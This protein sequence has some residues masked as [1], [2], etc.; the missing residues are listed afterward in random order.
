MKI[1]LGIPVRM[2]STRFPGKPLCDILGKS[3]VEHVYRRCA[4]SRY[5]T[6]LFVAAC[7][8]EVKDHVEGF[9]GKVVMTDP[10]ISRA[11]LRV[12]TAA[13][14]YDLEPED[15]VVVIQGDEPLVH[16]E[17]IDLAIKP[18]LEE[19]D[20]FVSNL[21]RKIEKDEWKDPA[22][23]KVVC[24]L[25][26]NAMYMS[27]S[28]IPSIAHEEAR[29]DWWKQVCIMPFRW[30]FMQKFN[31]ELAETPLE[32]QESVEMLRAMQHGYKVRMVPSLYVSKS[33]DTEN[34]R[35]EVARLMA[36]DVIYK[37][38]K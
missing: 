20:L 33:V 3:M 15:I 7:D 5:A 10:K 35:Q 22:E 34:D 2:A 23:I 27:R 24:D 38:Y 19:K 18:L 30:H 11:G 36:D 29:C 6:D 1:M 26:M 13:E 17:M 37:T 14:T 16:P 8:P 31:H 12:A 9:G 21:C 32:L 28:P 4:L 25:N